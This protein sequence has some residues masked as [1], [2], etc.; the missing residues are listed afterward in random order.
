MLES[1]QSLMVKAQ[2]TLLNQ[3]KLCQT[4]VSKDLSIKVDH[5]KSKSNQ[6]QITFIR[7]SGIEKDLLR[8]QNQDKSTEI[9]TCS[10][11]N[12][13]SISLE[14]DDNKFLLRKSKIQ[15]DKCFV[16]SNKLLKS[17]VD[18]EI[19][20][21]S[22]K[23]KALFATISTD[24]VDRCIR[25]SEASKEQQDSHIYALTQ[26]L[27]KIMKEIVST[28]D[29]KVVK[30]SEILSLVAIFKDLDIYQ[31]A[32]A[33]DKNV[34]HKNWKDTLK[35]IGKRDES[36]HELISQSKLYE[37]DYRKSKGIINRSKHDINVAQELY[38][39]KNQLMKNMKKVCRLFLHIIRIL[40][41]F[42]A[43]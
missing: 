29:E 31:C 37:D 12:I 7:I 35:A 38:Q 43:F 23:D 19:Y 40:L 41:F 2:K 32:V 28:S 11:G 17:I 42:F 1:N 22:L 20:W 25:I 14:L 39:D 30:E 5:L 27:E 24:R 18:V 4:N 8:I 36:I 26:Q 34:L 13:E 6:Y 3:L 10:D 33:S 15:R 9:A 16:E 21:R